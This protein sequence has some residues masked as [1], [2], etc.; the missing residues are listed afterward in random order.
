MALV[1]I[2]LVA[3]NL[4]TAVSSISPI[5]G[6][7][8][9]DIHLG[10]IGLS[11]MGMVPPV[12]FAV[13]GVFSGRGARKVGLEKFLLWAVVA[14]FIGLA[15]RAL[16]LDYTMLL[17]GNAVSL[18]GAGVGNVLLPP[19]VKRYFP[20]RI[21]LVTALYSIAMSVSTAIP[22]AFSA[23][24]SEAAG[25]RTSLGAWAI[26]A[27]ASAVP[28][29]LLVF[30]QQ[31]E[32]RATSV[33]IELQEWDSRAS[34]ALWRSPIAWSITAV[35]AV[36]AFHS[37]SILAWMPE[38]L[39]QKVGVTP[40]E[41]GGLFGLL[42]IMGVPAALLVPILAARIHNVTLLIHAG[43]LSFIL[44]YLGLIFAPTIAPVLWVLLVGSGILLFSTCLV[45]INLFTRS[46]DGAILLSGIVQGVGY[47]VGSLGP[48]FV[49]ML[50]N[51]TGGW[52]ASLLLLIGTAVGCIFAAL[53]LRKRRYLEDELATSGLNM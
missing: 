36:S 1:G 48:L 23:P 41:A 3:L 31:W 32:K 19:V 45:L 15:I 49:G 42:T 29:A 20:H 28:W 12:A 26:L 13:A 7:I 4:R 17:A 53:P 38:I 46:Q 47:I 10:E 5:A 33:V 30:K 39:V 8:S 35:F 43:L 52:N 27:I 24:L 9:A 40:A 22:A 6:A 34:A 37:Y 14:M 25:W 18:V 51:T 21:G 44:G 11:A 16:A 2:L 50:R